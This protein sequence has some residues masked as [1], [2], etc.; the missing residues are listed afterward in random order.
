MKNQEI[1]RAAKCNGLNIINGHALHPIFFSLTSLYYK[2]EIYQKM[3][4]EKL[5]N[6]HETNY[7]ILV[8]SVFKMHKSL[9]DQIRSC[10][11][12][13]LFWYKMNSFFSYFLIS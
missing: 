7:F 8:L 6:L 11:N 3:Q 2:N 9:T 10:E 12:D 5:Y 1:Q 4:R 13:I